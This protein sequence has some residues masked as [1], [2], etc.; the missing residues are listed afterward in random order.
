MI[1]YYQEMSNRDKGTCYYLTAQLKKKKDSTY[2]VTMTLNKTHDQNIMLDSIR[3]VMK[4][5]ETTQLYELQ[6][7]LPQH[8]KANSK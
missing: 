1:R 7:Q 3:N 4:Q 2:A 8:I 5:L 6:K